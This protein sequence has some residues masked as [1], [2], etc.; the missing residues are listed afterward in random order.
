MKKRASKTRSLMLNRETIRNL[1]TI[2]DR[3]LKPV[4]GASV[5]PCETWYCTTAVTCN[6]NC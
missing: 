6:D 4:V 2:S 5:H 1:S 3:D